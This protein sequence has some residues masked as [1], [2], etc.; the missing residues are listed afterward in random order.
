MRCFMVRSQ[1]MIA[2]LT[3]VVFFVATSAAPALAKSPVKLGNSLGTV[4]F[5][6]DG[7]GQPAPTAGITSF[8]LEGNA[9]H[10]GNYKA[11]GEVNFV[12]GAGGTLVGEGVVV[13]E[14]ANGDLLAGNVS[15]T[16]D[17]ADQDGLS[18]SAIGFHWADSITLSN[19]TIVSSTGRF[20]DAKG[21]PPGLVVIAIIA[22][23]IG[24][25]V[26]AVQK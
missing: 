6:K 8:T 20:Q 9:S 16:V 14:A 18:A 17:P 21:R 4:E 19:G 15:W 1:R 2:L 25:L 22:I 13:F 23:L 26:P 12:P 11:Q 3:A 5:P 7:N 10:L 24:L